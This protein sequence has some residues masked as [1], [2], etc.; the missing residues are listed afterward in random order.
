MCR[1]SKQTLPDRQQ[2]LPALLNQGGSLTSPPLLFMPPQDFKPF[3]VVGTPG[4]LAELS[5][6]GSLQTHK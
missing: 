1:R 2:H 5:R 6:D 4:R 3:M